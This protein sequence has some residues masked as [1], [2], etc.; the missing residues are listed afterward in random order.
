MFSRATLSLEEE[1]RYV[2]GKT[3]SFLYYQLLVLNLA[4]GGYV[5]FTFP[6]YHGHEASLLSFVLLGLFV[7]ATITV[8]RLSRI[9]AENHGEISRVSTD[10]AIMPLKFRDRVLP[11]QL[12]LGK[13][14]FEQLRH[15]YF[16]NAL[17]E[18][19]ILAPGL[20]IGLALVLPSFRL[21]G[22]LAYFLLYASAVLK[23]EPKFPTLEIQTTTQ[24]TTQ[25]NEETAVETEREELS[26][27]WDESTRMKLVRTLSPEGNDRLEA[28]VRADFSSGER[29]VSLHIPF[30]PNFEERPQIDVYQLEGEETEITVAQ[31]NPLGVRLDLKRPAR[32]KGEESVRLCLFA[33][34]FCADLESGG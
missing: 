16:R 14:E 29:V 13:D 3:A 2:L 10:E 6:Y 11:L 12:F 26:E 31:V 32:R 24:T 19:L 17:P 9:V 25:T 18:L 5:L 4:L 28:C 20:L 1:C 21:F 8:L 23:W 33:E 27:A 30:S 34:H 15:G 7:R 22:L